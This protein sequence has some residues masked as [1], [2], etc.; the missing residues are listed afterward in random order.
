MAPTETDVTRTLLIKSPRKQSQRVDASSIIKADVFLS[1][2]LKKIDTEGMCLPFFSFIASSYES[3]F[4][5]N[6]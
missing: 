5:R 6:G 3:V 2:Y 4:N 1:W